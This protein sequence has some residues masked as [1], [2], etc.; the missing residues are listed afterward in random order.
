MNKF[1]RIFIIVF[2]TP[3]ILYSQKDSIPTLILQRINDTGNPVQKIIKPNKKIKILTNENKKYECL[4]II[5]L[6]DSSIF[7]NTDTILLKNIKNITA[8]YKGCSPL[9]LTLIVAGLACLPIAIAAL[10]PRYGGS[11]DAD[12]WNN[13]NKGRGKFIAIEI[14]GFWLILDGI[15]IPKTR[16]FDTENKWIIKVGNYYKN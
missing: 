8:K 6:S 9:K 14:T 2:I 11:S 5:L 15:A 10:L 3:I 12:E 4:H 7:L 13:Y 1:I 16:K